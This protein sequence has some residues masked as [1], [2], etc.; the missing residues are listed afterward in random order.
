MLSGGGIN[1]GGGHRM[2][3]WLIT[4]ISRGLGRALAQAALQAGDRVVGTVRSDPPALA[5]AGGR[6]LVLKADMA[7]PAA[8]ANMVG[9]AFSRVGRIDVLVNNA[10]FGLL[11]AVEHATDE[12]M[13]DLF[14]VDL[15]APVRI[16]RAAIPHLRAQGG[17]HVVNITS[18]AGRAPG[19]GAALYAAAK[20]AM[21]GFS[22]AIAQELA[23]FGIKVT[24]VAPG[25]F[26]TAFL[27]EGSLKK[28]RD[29]AGV[30]AGTLGA[31]LQALQDTSL[32]QPGDPDRAAQAILQAVAA[33]DPPLH[34]LLGS[35]AL[36][37]ARAKLQAMT[38]EIEA[39]EAATLSTDFPG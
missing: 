14:A 12:E 17:G 22:A 20:A 8:V 37:R 5:D 25:Q 29:A 4:G 34:L 33:E 18:I 21:E 6:L 11:G 27:S 24:A 2:K 9:T 32:A 23:P 7:N 19:P 28:S 30:Y 31:S 36:T 15:F 35:D 13:Q 26:R 3:T 16:I 1:T 10:G 39:W 38:R